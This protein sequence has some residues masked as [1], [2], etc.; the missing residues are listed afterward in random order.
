VDVGRDQ[1]EEAVGVA[2][3]EELDR[4][5]VGR[6]GRIRPPQRLEVGE[7]RDDVKRHHHPTA[8]ERRAVAQ[9]APPNERELGGTVAL[10]VLGADH[11]PLGDGSLGGVVPGQ[12]SGVKRKE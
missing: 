1:A 6:V 4:D 11:L 9:E 7:Q 12:G 2:L 3:D 8:D 5:L 10:L